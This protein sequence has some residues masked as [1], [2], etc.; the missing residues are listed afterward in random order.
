MVNYVVTDR[1]TGLNQSISVSGGNFG[2]SLTTELERIEPVIADRT[3]AQRWKVFIS[4]SQFGLEEVSSLRDDEVTFYDTTDNR[5]NRL[6]VVDGQLGL[7]N[8][9]GYVLTDRTTGTNYE[10]TIQDNQMSLTETTEEAQDDPVV[11]EDD[12][13]SLY[14]VFIDD[15]EL[16]FEA[17]VSPFVRQIKLYDSASSIF[18][19]IVIIGNSLGWQA[20]E[21]IKR[22]KTT[23]INRVFT[24]AKHRILS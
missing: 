16:G 19:R 23:R 17:T 6:V 13:L 10:M 18:Y 20:I 8:P 4:D 14:K 9:F 24:S 22:F 12:T 2:L 5:Y 1:T 15:G 21:R 11:I 3:T 7:S